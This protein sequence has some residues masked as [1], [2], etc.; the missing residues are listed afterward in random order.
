MP[1]FLLGMSAW[2]LIYEKRRVG[3]VCA[4]VAL[5]TLPFGA[6]RYDP[7]FHPHWAMVAYIGALGGALLMMLALR[8]KVVMGPLGWIGLR[9]YSLYLLHQALGVSTLKMLTRLG[10]PDWF[11][12]TVVVL[13]SLGLAH[14]S[15][16]Y[17]EGPA[18][19][20]IN[21]FYKQLTTARRYPAASL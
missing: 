5:I 17:I 21:R 10:A 9:S 6:L 18:G 4:G 20:A 1:L 15:F 19:M 16:T 14:L 11:S 3:W 2:L 13:A 8:I 7:A 12:L